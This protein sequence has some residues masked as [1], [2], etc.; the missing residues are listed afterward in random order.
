MK[1]IGDT[2]VLSKKSQVVKNTQHPNYEEG[3]TFTLG[4]NWAECMVEISAL[5]KS[6]GRISYNTQQQKNNLKIILR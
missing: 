1:V 6:S 2:S 3:F 4:E 5:E